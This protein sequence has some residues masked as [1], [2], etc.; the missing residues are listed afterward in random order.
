M[1]SGLKY[2]LFFVVILLIGVLLQLSSPRKL[3]WE[4]TYRH[5]DSQPFGC[6]VLDSVLSFTLPQGYQVVDSSLYTLAQNDSGQV[7]NV[8]LI[9]KEL[10]L[11]DYE[12][13]ALFHLL[14]KGARVMLVFEWVNTQLQDTLGLYCYRA[15]SY[16]ELIK[17]ANEGFQRDTLEWVGDSI[18]YPVA[19][20]TPYS[21]FLSNGMVTKSDTAW[22]RHTYHNSFRSAS[23]GNFQI[24]PLVWTYPHPRK[25]EPYSQP[26]RLLAA[27]S[28][29]IGKGTLYIVRTP[30]LFSNYGIL[31]PQCR[32]YLLRMFSQLSNAPLIRTEYY[33][34]YYDP[35]H[36]SMMTQ[37]T[38]TPFAYVLAHPPLRWA[39]YLLIGLLVVFL[40]CTARRRQ[41][42]IPIIEPIRNQ[43]LE[44]VKLIGMLYF[45]RES[46]AELVRRKYLYFC[47][48]VQ[49]RS[50]IRPN[51][52]E[53]KTVMATRLAEAA[54]MNSEF[55]K[56]MLFRLQKVVSDNT[57]EIDTQ[58][59]KEL[60]D[61]MNEL[62]KAI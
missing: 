12:V 59:M 24:K 42:P 5:L 28:M 21:L 38:Q 61:W 18:R 55:V 14:N 34:P 52:E 4:E 25:I 9:G 23:C 40:I 15:P 39:L 22:L 26:D 6:S 58:E 46:P 41:R 51:D 17:G 1:K 49:R 54:G 19:R 11:K 36:S 27:A 30:R 7:D 62:I 48:E 57:Q 32:T 37:K 56:R 20:Y 53:E 13:D 45:R 29:E 43:S 44:F 31:D 60:I 50:G 8:M 16:S 2:V 33:L 47:D 35:S 10:F 3:V